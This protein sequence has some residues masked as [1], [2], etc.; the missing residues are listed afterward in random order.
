MPWCSLS[1]LVLAPQCPGKLCALLAQSAAARSMC[2]SSLE[3]PGLAGALFF[4][5]TSSLV[6]ISLVLFSSLSQQALFCPQSDRLSSPLPLARCLDA[7]KCPAEFHDTPAV[8]GAH[9][10]PCFSRGTQLLS[11]MSWFPA[12]SCP[13]CSCSVLEFALCLD[14]HSRLPGNMLVRAPSIFVLPQ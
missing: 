2:Y 1:T 3:C 6:T 10:V 5:I 7:N 14:R 9:S 13:C 8:S 12:L 4:H 11:R